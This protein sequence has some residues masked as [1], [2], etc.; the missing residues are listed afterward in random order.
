S[1]CAFATVL[2]C[3]SVTIIVAFWLSPLA[4]GFF[5]GK[6]ATCNFGC[7]EV[8]IEDSELFDCCVVSI[9]ASDC[10]VSIGASDCV[11][12]I[13]GL[14]TFDCCVVSIGASDCVVSIGASDVVSIGAL[15]TLD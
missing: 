6:I 14:V 9:G 10:V 15:V 11:V 4:T 1:I 5:S 3:S 13:G 12:S 7:C 2:L 8:S